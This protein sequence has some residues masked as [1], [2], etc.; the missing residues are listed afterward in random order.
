MDTGAIYCVKKGA[1]IVLKNDKWWKIADTA[2]KNEGIRPKWTWNIH[3]S[4]MGTGRK[5]QYEESDGK[6]AGDK[7]TCW[8]RVIW[9]K[10]GKSDKM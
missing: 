10:S 5:N 8:R 6:G 9:Q 2:R 3:V 7:K 1:E 4:G